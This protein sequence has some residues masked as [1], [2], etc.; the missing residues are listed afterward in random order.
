MH[1]SSVTLISAGL[2]AVLECSASGEPVPSI[3]WQ[4]EGIN[5]NTSLDKVS[6]RIINST[7]SCSF[8]LNNENTIKTV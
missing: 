2:T 3:I 7:F 6:S 1:P 8:Q 5:V 4:H